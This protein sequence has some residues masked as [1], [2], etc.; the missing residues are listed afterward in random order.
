MRYWAVFCKKFSAIPV[1]F[2]PNVRAGR[3]TFFS[4]RRHDVSPFFYLCTTMPLFQLKFSRHRISAT[5]LHL[6]GKICD[7]N[8]LLHW[9]VFL[10]KFLPITFEINV[11]V[12]CLRSH[13]SCLTSTVSDLLSFESCPTSP[14]SHLLSHGSCLRCCLL[15]RFSCLRSPVFFL[16]SLVSRFMNHVPSTVPNSVADPYHF[17]TDPDPGCDHSN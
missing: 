1:P 13:I 16:T 9:A 6:Q 10:K 5:A 12:S 14:V 4:S 3:A 2:L 7:I 8:K 11:L 17:D 15:S